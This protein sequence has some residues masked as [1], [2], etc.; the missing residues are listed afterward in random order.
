MIVTY[1]KKSHRSK[2]LL[3]SKIL[4]KNVVGG[5]LKTYLDTRWTTVHEMLDSISRLEI[6]LKEVINENPNVITNEAIKTIINRKRGFFNDVTDLA[7]IMKPIKEAILNLE[8]SNATLADCYFH[9]AYLGRSINKIPDDDHVIFRQYAIK[10]FNE[11]FKAYD[12]D[13]YLLAYYIHPGYK[14]ENFTFIKFSDLNVSKKFNK[15]N[16]I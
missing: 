15:I 13:E 1:F 11:R 10:I 8:S 9:L 7:N 3:D 2:E 4:E 6:C 16:L 5:G 14:G 12:F